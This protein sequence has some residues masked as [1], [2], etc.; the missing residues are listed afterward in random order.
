[1]EV[2]TFYLTKPEYSYK[3]ASISSFVNHGPKML[4]ASILMVL[5]EPLD[6]DCDP[7]YLKQTILA[8]LGTPRLAQ[9]RQFWVFCYLSYRNG[10]WVP[11]IR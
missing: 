2:V 11:S 4:T 8:F 1:M 10:F 9:I 3:Y 5:F 6:Y 7:Q